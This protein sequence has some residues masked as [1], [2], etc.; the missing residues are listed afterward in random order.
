MKDWMAVRRLLN[1]AL[2]SKRV[3]VAVHRGCRCGN[4][5]ENT[6][7]GL[8]TVWRMGGDI[9]ELDVSASSDG[10]LYAFHDDMERYL[11]EKDV[12]IREL[13]SHEVDRMVY[14]N[15]ND[16]PAEPVNRLEDVLCGL[17]GKGLINID[18]AWIHWEK[19]LS[20]V[21]R[22]GMADQAIVKTPVSEEYL[23]CLERCETPFMYMP[24]MKTTDELEIVR[25]YRI[26]TVGCELLF[27]TEDHP[28]LDPVF[29]AELK[30]DGSFLWCNAITLGNSILTAGHDDDGAITVDPVA[31]W[32]W[33]VEHGFNVIQTDWPMLL[34]DFLRLRFPV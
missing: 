31:N 7:K 17:K 33:L 15:S 21:E 8:K 32:G 24:I 29:Q 11:L 28:F 26:N 19:T 20:M 22:L 34:R 23:A 9:A 16:V 14:R 6:L 30:R 5:V 13:P 18:R 3:L 2:C 4:I 27:D 25:K 12:N 10:V 1:D